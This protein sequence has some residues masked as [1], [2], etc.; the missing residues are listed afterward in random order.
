MN[1]DIVWLRDDFRLDDQPAILAAADRPALLVYVHDDSPRNGRPLGGAAKWRLAQS[2]KA[3]EEALAARGGRLDVI[4]RRGR[5]DHPRARRRG[6][7]R[8]R[9][10]DPALRGRVD[11]A[12]RRRQDA[13]ARARR[14]GPE[15]QRPAHARAVGGR[16]AGRR[17]LRQLFRLLAPASRPWPPARAVARARPPQRARLGPR[18]RR[19]ASRSTALRLTPT[20]AGL[21]GRAC[22]RREP[23]RTGR[24]R[25]AR[26]VRRRSA[27]RLCRRPR[28]DVARD[29]LA[30]LGPP[31][32]RRSFNRAAS[33]PPSRAP[34]PPGRPCSATPKNSWPSSAGA[35]SP[36]R[37]SID[38]PISRR[39]RCGAN[40]NA[41]LARRR[42]GLSRLGAWA[43]RL[44]DRRRRHAPALAHRIHAQPRADD[45]GLVPRQAPAHRL[46]PRRAMVLG[47]ALPTPTPP[48]TR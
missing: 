7:R 5:Q 11:R 2:L 47:H 6:E 17:A 48:A 25:R 10:L 9:S 40:S 27:R 44:S 46:A 38:I 41:F 18:M 32:L 30:A 24:A 4:A 31:A 22:A 35:T 8:P 36:R 14:R 37:F 28:S 13:P 16:K 34:P 42:R 12:R 26:P 3:M 20:E 19:N 43:D 1:G 45:R 29:D 21:V 15:L 33:P 23:R 39:G